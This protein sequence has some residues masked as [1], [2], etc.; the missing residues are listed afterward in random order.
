MNSFSRQGKA[1]PIKVRE[2]IIEKCLAQTSVAEISRQLRLPHKTVSNIVDVWLTRPSI[3]PQLGGNKSR[4]A[5]TEDVVMYT[6]FSKQSKPSVYAK[7]I[8]QNLVENGVCL[9]E[10]TPSTASISRILTNDLG[11]SYKKLSRIAR[12]SER[13]DVIEKLHEYLA[14]ISDI[15]SGRLH[16]FDESSVIV[17]SGN[18]SRGHSA[19][20]NQAFEVQRYASNATYT[21]NLLH[22]VNGV[23]HFNI[24]RGPSNGLELLNFFEEALQQEDMFGNPVIKLDD[25]IVMDNCG[26]HHGANVEP[27]LRN[28]LQERNAELVFQPPYHPCFNTCEPCFHILKT[29]LRRYPIYTEKYTDLCIADAL[30][31]LTS[32]ISRQIFKYCGYL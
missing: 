18:R 2:E 30:E 28:M 6:E 23:S 15:D 3:E 4:T 13:E 21:I 10:N 26:F 24:I 19:V 11:Y 17:T 14:K 1:L 27:L 20:G 22:N 16:F 29:I 9:P 8:Q 32:G 25:I 31:M 5:R 7:E 12:E